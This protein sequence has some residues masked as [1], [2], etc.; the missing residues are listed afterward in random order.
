MIILCI[1]LSICVRYKYL[2]F[3]FLEILNF[4]RRISEWDVERDVHDCRVLKIKIIELVKEKSNECKNVKSY[5]FEM[6]ISQIQ[7]I[8][9]DVK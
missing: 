5:K 7:M 6:E 3:S 8:F 4:Q 9:K 1:Y 2:I